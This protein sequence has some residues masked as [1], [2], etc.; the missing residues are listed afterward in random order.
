MGLL[1][2]LS[3]ADVRQLVGEMLPTFLTY[4]RFIVSYFSSFRLYRMQQARQSRQIRMS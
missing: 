2:G 3:L 1:V 4:C